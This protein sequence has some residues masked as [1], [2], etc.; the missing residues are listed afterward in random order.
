MLHMIAMS[1]NNSIHY[2]N[3]WV[4]QRH[5]D[6]GGG[7]QCQP[8]FSFGDINSGGLAFL[9]VLLLGLRLKILGLSRPPQV[10]V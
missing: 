4:E 7:Q 6:A 1:S 10:Y 3:S 9:R 2:T 5:Q 8:S